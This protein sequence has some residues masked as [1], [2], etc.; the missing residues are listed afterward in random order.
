[1]AR[2]SIRLLGTGLGL[3]LAGCGGGG[4]GSA[5]VSQ[6]SGVS[7][8]SANVNTAT[9]VVVD[10]S[11]VADGSSGGVAFLTGVVTQTGPGDFHFADFALQQLARIAAQPPSSNTL[12]GVSGSGP[13]DCAAAGRVLY[14]ATVSNPNYL[15][16][17]DMFHLQ[18]V[19]CQENGSTLDGA[20]AMTVNAVS[21]NFD[22]S[23]PAAPYNLTIATELANFSAIDATSNVLANGDLTIA[24]SDNGAG[25]TTLELSGNALGAKEGTESAVLTDYDYLLTSDSTS[26]DFTLDAMATVGSSK[27]GGSVSFMTTT[28]FSGNVSQSGG[29]FTAGELQITSNIDASNAI[30]TALSDGA[31]VQI[32][33]DE[34]GGG[35]YTTSMTTWSDLDAL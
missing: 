23:A 21:A 7:V 4:G 12:T 18:F 9:A 10:S 25:Y 20:F 16:V 17:G 31:N 1:M 6:F 22:P 26:G 30:V 35:S 5:V 3:L 34:S 13:L 14:T 33:L 32:R 2:A 15:T 29:N 27:L 11:N 8:T 19:G 28:T 24:T